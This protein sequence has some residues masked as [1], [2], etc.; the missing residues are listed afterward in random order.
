MNKD[1]HDDHLDDY[2]RKSFDDYEEDPQ[3]NMWNRI[4]QA[5][6]Q[7]EQ[8]RRPLFFWINRWNIAASFV[9]FS[10][11]AGLAY[12]HFYYEGKIQALSNAQSNGNPAPQKVSPPVVERVVQPSTATVE[13]Q[14][15][16]VFNQTPQQV[17]Q[18]VIRPVEKNTQKNVF[19][20]KASQNA[21]VGANSNLM[22]THNGQAIISPNLPVLE[23]ATTPVEHIFATN[24][25]PPLGVDD[26]L[27][28]PQLPASALDLLTTEAPH[29]KLNGV[30]VPIIQPHKTRAGWYVGVQTSR[31]GLKE[32]GVSAD[33]SDDTGMGHHQVSRQQ[34]V[35][36]RA[37][38]G[39]KVGKK[40]S[41]NFGLESGVSYRSFTRVAA[42]SP[43]FRFRDGVLL[44]H[45]PGSHRHFDFSYNLDTYS[46]GTEVT[47]RMEE[48][49]NT[50][51]LPDEPLVM[52][53][54][55]AEHTELIRVPLLLT[56]QHQ[57]GPIALVAKTGLVGNMITSSQLDI[58][59]RIVG[60]G[61]FQPAIGTG[62]YSLKQLTTDRL[63]LGY[64]CSAGV[65]VKLGQHL[66]GT[67][68]MGLS[69]D[70]NRKHQGSQKL[71][72]LYTSGITAGV[73]YYF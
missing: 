60:A 69:G 21:I 16:V 57:W 7:P 19:R 66:A 20:A 61:R 72:G 70:F 62:A 23:Q 14:S 36:S 6:E 37:E 58:T 31:F 35:T 22:N 9:I 49:D 18:S 11:L 3:D 64:Q 42:H 43:R 40:I 27:E 34:K 68:D 29:I 45:N 48:V 10:L 38:F 15:P 5:L 25:V 63:F 17:E 51:A 54:N 2:V 32:Q 50:P 53:I 46:G 71:P 44:T 55:T 65:E 56:A 26:V 67:L 1:I 28:L 73:N 39:I 33:T 30:I 13:S 24:Q 12:S 41:R 4:E 8:P 52:R 59:S 47:L